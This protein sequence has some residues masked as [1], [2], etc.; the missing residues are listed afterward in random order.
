MAAAAHL[1]LSSRI[2]ILGFQRPHLWG[3]QT[4]PGH[5]APGFHRPHSR[6]CLRDFI[7]MQIPA[8]GAPGVR[9]RR[10]GVRRCAGPG[11]GPRPGLHGLGTASRL[12]APGRRPALLRGPHRT[13]GK[14]ESQVSKGGP[15]NSGEPRSS[16]R[17]SSSARLAPWGFMHPQARD[18]LPAPPSP[19]PVCFLEKRTVRLECIC[20]TL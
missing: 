8:A 17:A 12:A 9:R 6:H 16:G 20:L 3:L 15:G 7:D 11:E 1:A 5:Q 10:G 13:P 2:C 19:P 14:E 4:R 18:H